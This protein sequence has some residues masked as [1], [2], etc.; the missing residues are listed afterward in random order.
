MVFQGGNSTDARAMAGRVSDVMLMNGDT[1]AGFSRIIYDTRQAA[2]LA[3]R[4]E[5]EL[6]FGANAFCIVRQSESEAIDTLHEIVRRADRDAVCEFASAVRQAGQSTADNK[7]MWTDSVFED[8]VQYND[9]FKTDLI[10]TATQVADRII[11]LKELG[12]NIIL[13]GFLHYEWE[14]Q[15]FG[16]NVIPLVRERE[17]DL[18]RRRRSPIR[19]GST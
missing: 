1:N 4:S 8:L 11:E 18:R 14:L 15:E 5:D 13:C 7:G 2:R 9:G 10:G 12:V 6:R 3:G 17:N 16:Q 19:L